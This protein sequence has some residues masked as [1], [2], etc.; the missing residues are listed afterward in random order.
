[1]KKLRALSHELRAKARGSQLEAHGLNKIL[2]W[3]KRLL[4]GPKT[5]HSGTMTL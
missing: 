2:I 4:P 3:V 1:M 5:I